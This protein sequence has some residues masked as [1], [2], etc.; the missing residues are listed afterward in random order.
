MQ[1]FSHLKAL[2]IW[3]TIPPSLDHQLAGQSPL[4]SRRETSS[5]AVVALTTRL[6]K[7]KKRDTPSFPDNCGHH[8][9]SGSVYSH[10]T[11]SQ[12]QI[13]LG[14]HLPT[15][16][17]SNRPIPASFLGNCFVCMAI[18]LFQ[19][20]SCIF[21]KRGFFISSIRMFLQAWHIGPCIRLKAEGLV[22]MVWVL[23][24]KSSKWAL[25]TRFF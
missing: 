12:H 16:E 13:R 6:V 17:T 10:P 23:E 4:S 22:F 15:S 25:I 24:W 8:K 1:V 21:R 19:V 2:S 20:L 11:T 5:P 18:L 7:D 3:D 14:L 9:Q